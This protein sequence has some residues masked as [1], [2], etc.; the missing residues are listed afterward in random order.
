MRLSPTSSSTLGAEPAWD[1]LLPVSLPLSRACALSFSQ[2]KYVNFKRNR[3]H[4]ALVWAESEPL[5]DVSLS[6]PVGSSAFPSADP[7]PSGWLALWL[8]DPDSKVCNPWLTLHCS[9]LRLPHRRLQNA[10]AES[11]HVHYSQAPVGQQLDRAGWG[12]L[13]SVP[14]DVCGDPYNPAGFFIVWRLGWEGWKAG[15]G[16]MRCRSLWSLWPLHVASPRSLTC[17][18]MSSMW[19]HRH[20]HVVGA[21]LPGLPDSKAWN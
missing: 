15:L 21:E 18:A 9:Y 2:N 12:W 5:C 19:R 10:V 20:P 8:W 6:G 1:F 7:T 4:R 17:R 13:T 3:R 11:D 14:R 16:G